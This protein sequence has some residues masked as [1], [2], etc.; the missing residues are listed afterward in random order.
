MY[1]TDLHHFDF[2]TLGAAE[3][4]GPM[5]AR[6]LYFALLDEDADSD[7]Q[8]RPTTHEASITFLRH[9]LADS[10]TA[11]CDLPDRLSGLDA[12]MTDHTNAVLAEY[13]RYLG[14]RKSGA[15]RQYFPTKSHALH[16]LTAVA[17]TKTVDGSWLFGLLAH[18]QDDRF[19]N[20]IR[21]YLDEL[22]CGVPDQ[23]HV[24]LF[25]R[26]LLANGCERW[27]YL[28]DHHFVQ[29][30]IQ[31]ALAHHAE[32][33][34]PELIG[35]NLGYE[36]LPL[37]LLITAYELN[38]LGIDPTYFGLHVTVDNADS[39]HARQ[40]LQGLRDSLPVVGDRQAFYRRVISG[41]RL[42][43]LGASTSSVIAD[44][45]LEAELIAVL[46]RKSV[47]GKQAHADYCRIGGRTVNDWLSEPANMPAFVEALQRSGW[48]KRGEAAENS[49]FWKLIDGERADMFGVFSAYEQQ[50]LRDWI[51]SPEDGHQLAIPPAASAPVGRTLTFKS[52]Q[53]LLDN[54]DRK[55]P[56]TRPVDNAGNRFVERRA[57]ARHRGAVSTSNIDESND[58][59]A[60]LRELTLQLAQAE[61]KQQAMQI[62][63]SLMT[64]AR[65]HTHAGLHATRIFVRLFGA[66]A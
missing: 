26:L 14:Q 50:V 1:T 15:P 33:F 48:I 20:L 52:R 27:D 44:F 17:P 54:L 38:E 6:N 28:D 10:K 4:G 12:W 11:R 57:V 60:E 39:G 18:W 51:S 61:D 46:S 59:N 30:A 41:Y 25:K 22:G 3:C 47:A 29:G 19:S 66:S 63:I 49:R 56:S 43:E 42:N 53:R 13:Q 35:F 7:A 64:P 62:L 45:D 5:G 58:F 8:G 37:H 34:L 32:Q 21:I 65:H 24:A 16:F 2:Q 23:N 9:A 40:A 36:Q 31:L 55:Q